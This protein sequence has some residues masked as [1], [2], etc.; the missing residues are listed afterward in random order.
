MCESL[1]VHKVFLVS[2]ADIKVHGQKRKKKHKTKKKTKEINT[3]IIPKMMILKVSWFG[4]N[5]GFEERYSL[6]QRKNA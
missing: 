2:I 6:S 4:Q 3:A 1:N 5:N